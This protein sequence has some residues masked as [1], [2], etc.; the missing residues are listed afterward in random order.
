M[1]AR[2]TTGP[3]VL[4]KPGRLAFPQAGKKEQAGILPFVSVAGYPCV[5]EGVP[6]EA[7]TGAGA[8]RLGLVFVSLACQRQA[9]LAGFPSKHQ[10]DPYP[11]ELSQSAKK[12]V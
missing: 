8:L 7:R 5:C 1:A 11:F 2:E 10:T 3:P 4:T 12:T 6:W 9:I